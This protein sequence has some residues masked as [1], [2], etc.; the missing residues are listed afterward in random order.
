MIQSLGRYILLLR[1][2][3]RKPEKFTVYW[4]EVMRE[5]VSAGIGS[6]GIIM[7]IS[8]FIGAAVTIQTA[9]QLV[10]PLIAKSVVGGITRDSMV[11]EFSPTIS[12]LVLAGRVGSSMA[13]QIGTMRVTEQIDALEIMGVNA[14]GYL[15]SP[16]VIAGVSMFPLLVI[17]SVLLGFMGG[18]IACFSSNEVTTD[19]FMLGLSDGFNSVIITVCMVK[20]VV[21]GFII[22]TICSYQGFYTKGGALEVGQAATRGVVYSCVMI[23]LFDLI[24]SRLFL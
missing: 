2:S 5:M 6:L 10:S 7:I 17:V 8:L 16:K 21:F 18:Y 15:I 23:L 14:P 22:T 11:L 19:D 12:S 3:F 20:A 1:L 13:S 9:F 24:I 4:A